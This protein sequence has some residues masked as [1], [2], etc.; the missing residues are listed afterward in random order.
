M[1]FNVIRD[2]LPFN[3]RDLYDIFLRLLDTFSDRFWN[4][5]C[6]AE[7]ISN[8]TVTIAD[9]NECGEAETATTFDHRRAP[10]DLDDAIDVFAV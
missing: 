10:F 5:I 4:L 6:L 3:N 2:R 9:H 7:A 8:V 1:T